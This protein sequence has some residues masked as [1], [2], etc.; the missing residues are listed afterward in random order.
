MKKDAKQEEILDE[1]AREFKIVNELE[2]TNIIKVIEEFKVINDE[3][4]CVCIAMEF[5]KGKCFPLL[6]YRW[7]S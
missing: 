6:F 4:N 7:G 5:A 1:I 3:D 2:H